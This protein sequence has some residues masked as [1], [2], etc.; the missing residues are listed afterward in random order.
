MKVRWP[1]CSGK[2]LRSKTQQN[3]GSIAIGARAALG[4]EHPGT[5]APR[6]EGPASI[7]NHM[8]GDLMRSAFV[9]F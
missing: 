8:Y 2:S 3:W 1:S 9:L 6:D 4:A 5:A 7:W